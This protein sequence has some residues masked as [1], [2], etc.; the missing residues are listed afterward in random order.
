M[1]NLN[2][3]ASRLYTVSVACWLLFSHLTAAQDYLIDQIRLNIQ[4]PI[5][6]DYFPALLSSPYTA[7][8]LFGLL[9]LSDVGLIIFKQFQLVFAIVAALCSYLISIHQE[10]FF[11]QSMVVSLWT[12]LFLCWYFLQ[13]ERDEQK[14][15]LLSRM[16]ISLV[17]FCGTIGKMTPEYW[18]GEVFYN[19]HFPRFSNDLKVITFYSRMTVIAE[20]VL[21]LSFSVRHRL[22]IYVTLLMIVGMWILTVPKAV[23]AVGPLVGLALANALLVT[24]KPTCFPEVKF[25]GIILI[26]TAVWLLLWLKVIPVFHYVLNHF[27]RSI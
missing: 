11:V 2:L 23:D 6:Q 16:V 1:V 10:G 5:R 12:S 26:Y 24:K 7:V 3:S 13:K 4:T 8:G 14:V 19:L 9:L 21:A 27:L 18:S 20:A 22:M 17:F 15:L 25:G